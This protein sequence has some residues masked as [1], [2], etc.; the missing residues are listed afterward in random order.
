[1]VAGMSEFCDAGLALAR[2]AVGGK[3]VDL[4]RLL[5]LTESAI[6]QWKRIP[7]NRAIEIEEKTGGK[8]T[9]YELR[10]DFFGP[11]PAK[12]RPSRRKAA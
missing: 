10:P 5:G 12:S 4:A 9:R 6:S 3:A 11:A 8:V 7:P 2:E 1:M